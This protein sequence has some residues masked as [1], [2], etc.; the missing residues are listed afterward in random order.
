MKTQGL[1]FEPIAFNIYD[2]RLWDQGSRDIWGGK[3][4]GCAG[5]GHF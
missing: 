3:Y 4:E 2:F 5:V 1:G